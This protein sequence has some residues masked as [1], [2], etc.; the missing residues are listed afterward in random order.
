HHHHHHG[1]ISD[2]RKDAE[3]RMDKAV[4]AFK[5]KLDKF[6]AAVRKVFPTEERIKDWLKI[7][8]G[9]AEQARV[10]VRNVGRDA[11]DK[12]AALGKDKEIN[13]FDIS[14]SLWDVQKLTDAAIKKIEAALADMEAWLTQG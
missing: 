5:N 2:I 6:K 12:A 10:A 11:N 3:V 7:V 4:E 1:S 13:W 8:R 14:Q 9:E